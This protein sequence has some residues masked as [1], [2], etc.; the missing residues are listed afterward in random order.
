MTTGTAPARTN[1]GSAMLV[2]AVLAFAFPLYAFVRWMVIASGAGG[3]AEAV[4]R[5]QQGIPQALQ[6]RGSLE[7]LSAGLCLVTVVAA[8]VARGGTR[9]AA[10]AGLTSLVTVAALLG[11]W[12]VFTLM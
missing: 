12:N 4:A 1:T 2:V 8:A 3:H 10:R 9:G 6:S 5:F 7:W 11:L